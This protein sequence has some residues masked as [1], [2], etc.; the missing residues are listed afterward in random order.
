MICVDIN[1]AVLD[2]K[3][4][5]VKDIPAL[6]A[7]QWKKLLAKFEADKKKNPDFAVDPNENDLLKPTPKVVWTQGQ[8]RWHVDAPTLV[9][10]DKV[11]VASAFLDKE[12]EGDRALF[13]LNVADG[14]E[15][16]K[17]P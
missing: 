5:S 7:A 13:C 4:L 10:G 11:L 15:L 2:G 1:T 17:A 16:W 8:K 9:A 12:K 14:K 3:E 6:Q